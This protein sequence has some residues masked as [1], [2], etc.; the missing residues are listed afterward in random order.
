MSDFLGPADADNSVTVRPGE[1]RPCGA[2]DTWFVDCTSPTA[3]DGTEVQAAWF[4]GL[5][6]ALRSLWRSNGTLADG[7]TKIVAE[8]GTDDDGL[9][10]AVQQLVQ[11]GQVAFAV[12]NGTKNHLVIA[13]AP[14]LKEYKAG[15]VVRVRVKFANDGPAFI[16]VNGLGERAI[17]RTTLADLAPNDL[18]AAGIAVLVDD[19]TQFELVSGGAGGGGGAQGP[20]GIQGPQGVPGIQGPQGIPGQ[21]G[22][23]GPPGTFPLTPGAIGSFAIR[24]DIGGFILM[25]GGGPAS[26]P[27]SWQP[28]SSYIEGFFSGGGGGSVFTLVQRVA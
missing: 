10:K 11:R 5:L 8:T 17:K 27:G 16:N 14:A 7:T 28:L 25:N 9:T 2:L 12:D 15:V 22:L 20:Q 4:N 19:G 1:T 18:P 21:R 26:Y 23:Q 24:D 6:G 3:D 13:L